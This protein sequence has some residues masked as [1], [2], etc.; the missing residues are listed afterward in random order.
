ML[1]NHSVPVPARIHVNI[2]S[3]KITAIET[4]TISIAG[5]PQNNELHFSDKVI[6]PG[7]VDTHVHINEPGRTAWEGFDTATQAAAAGGVTTLVD[8]PLNC[9][10]V[11]TTAAALR[12]KID[13][14]TG[15]NALHV[16]VGFWGGVVPA[17]IHAL[18]ALAEAGVLGCKAFM[19]HSGIDDFPETGIDDLERAM[20]HLHK[21]NIPLLV[22]AELNVQV[23]STHSTNNIRSY[24]R[25]LESRPARWEED[26]IKAIITLVKKTGC[27]SHIVHL[28]AA[29][30]L[31]LISRAK[32]E[33][34]PLSVETCPHYLCIVAEDIPDGATAFKCAPPIRHR[35]NQDAL[36]AALLSGTIDMVTTDHSPCTPELKTMD[37]GSFDTAWGGISS[38]QLGLPLLWTEAKKRGA[39][40][41]QICRWL[42]AAPARCAG[43]DDAKGSI[44]VGQDGDFV[45]WSPETTFIV[46][47]NDLRYKNK[48]S[49]YAGR[50]LHGVVNATFLRG[51]EVFTEGDPPCVKGHGKLLL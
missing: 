3:G 8:M 34:L 13:C 30:A 12:T 11:T 33:G 2:Q 1:P 7:L 39:S 24:G 23:P 22:H 37:T 9:T 35:A 41:A 17:H 10:P 51:E 28:S 20:R 40:L 27:R 21:A 50:N 43:I 18:P 5:G 45:V 47:T 15:N 26:A 4:G 19:I 48:I 38:L 49:P 32:A 31:P 36:W 14:C 25:F 44:A 16:D 46:N 6:F 29:S 42:S